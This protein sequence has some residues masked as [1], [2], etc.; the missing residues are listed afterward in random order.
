MVCKKCGY[1]N[2]QGAVYCS[3]CGQ[4]LAETEKKS[5]P[6]WLNYIL[7]AVGMHGAH[8]AATD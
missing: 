6:K 3:G 2:A 5:K 7:I 8:E 4:K 1:Q